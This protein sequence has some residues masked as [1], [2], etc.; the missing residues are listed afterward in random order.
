MKRLIAFLLVC[1]LC[2]TCLA[3]CGGA[4][5]TA[6]APGSAPA[7]GADS[8][9]A[10]APGAAITLTFG[11]G[12]SE[13]HSFHKAAL[14]FQEL[15]Q[16]RSGGA[17]TVNIQPNGALGDEKEMAEGLQMGTV[18]MVV[19]AV[20]TLTGFDPGLDV[21][22]LPYLFGSREQGMAVLDGEIGRQ[23]FEGLEGQGL[24]LLGFFDL[25]F[26][27]M[28]NSQRP[29]ATPEDC[30]GLRMR[31]LQS[32]VLVEGLNAF[33]IDAVSMSFGELFTALQTGAVD[34]QE[35]PISVI[36]SS[37]FYEVQKYLS[38]TEHM[39]VVLPLLISTKTWEKLSA[40]QQQILLQCAQETVEHQREEN[41]ANYEAEL[42]DLKAN[43]MQ[44]NEVDKAAFQKAIQPLYDAYA[45]QFGET[46]EKI[47]AV[48]G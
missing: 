22:N 21:F 41:Q 18:D 10:P 16:E 40:D 17:I 46:V 9:A 24:K 43:G 48:K 25:G 39:Y 23:M 2:L 37:R 27:S 19:C 3:G 6:P 14:Y 32:N 35:N 33:G 4:A 38:L 42:A 29:I 34:G 36:D 26:R 12:Q 15:I 8:G 11:H 45:A 20:A 7:P 31:T 1:A 44:V 47:R 28:T 5:S 13:A 30:K